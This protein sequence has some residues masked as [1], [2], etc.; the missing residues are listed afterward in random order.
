MDVS[1]SE[2]LCLQ[3][4][5]WIVENPGSGCMP[6]PSFNKVWFDDCKA[7]TSTG[8]VQGIT[9]TTAVHGSSIDGRTVV[10]EW[11]DNADMYV[12]P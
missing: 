2:A 10:S 1:S 5:E 3:N 8:A 11:V 6:C 4:A 9:G 7:T 12:K